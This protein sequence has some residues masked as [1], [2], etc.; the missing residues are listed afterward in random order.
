MVSLLAGCSEGCGWAA[1]LVAVFAW[2]TFGV[3]LKCNVN[4][5]VNFFVMQSYKTL[6]CFATCWL[7][8]FLGEP[9]RWSPWGIVSGMFWVPGAACGIY[10]IRNAGVAI[11]VGTWSSIQVVSSCIFGIIIFQ[12]KV[13]DIKQT[14]LAFC[15]LMLGL[16]GMSRY[17]ETPKGHAPSLISTS[18]TDYEDASTTE[19]MAPL[20]PLPE[21]PKLKRK[22][23][24]TG[25]SSETGE[26]PMSPMIHKASQVG[27]VVTD[28]NTNNSNSIGLIP[29]EF[30][31]RQDFSAPLM[32]EDKTSMSKDRIVLFG[33]RL[34]LTKRQ[35]GILGAVFNGVWGGLN[36]VPLH[37]AQRDEGLSG[38][39]YLISYGTGSLLVCIS[40]WIMLF[41]YHFV[42][43]GYNFHD[44]VEQLPAWHVRE[45][46]LPGVL[47]GLFYSVGNFGAILAVAYLGQGVGFSFCQGQLLISGLWGVFYFKEIQGR[48]TIT[49]W[50]ASAIVT[51]FGIILLSYQHE[52]GSLHRS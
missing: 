48:E 50:F 34:A 36:L 2:G 43:R 42:K 22:N 8:I 47:A 7:V 4:V 37:Y 33:G 23:S 38:A 12:E 15:I 25:R 29:L 16:I 52:S 26:S 46:G 28:S 9:I 14:M 1:A 21:V 49:K 18:A 45:L 5:E 35:M 39:A 6:V 11:A 17:S 31:D 13:K 41:S 10:G 32:D 20:T 51:V 30:E 3:P 44:A 19:L 24:K 40:I 27:A